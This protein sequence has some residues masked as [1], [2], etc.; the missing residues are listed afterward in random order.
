MGT[1]SETVDHPVV[2]TGSGRAYAMRAR[3]DQD[4]PDAIAGTF[5][6]FNTNMHT[7]IDPGSTHSFICTRRVIDN[8][9]FSEPLE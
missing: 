3:E 6:L 1:T 5:S 8:M 9:P 7:L 4:A 2:P